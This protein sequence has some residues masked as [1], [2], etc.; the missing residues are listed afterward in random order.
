M[1]ILEYL[2]I[3]VSAVIITKDRGLCI[4]LVLRRWATPAEGDRTGRGL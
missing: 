4:I 2:H 3:Q 1:R